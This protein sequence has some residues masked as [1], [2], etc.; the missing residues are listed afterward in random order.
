MYGQN[1]D[2]E[3]HSKEGT[4]IGYKRQFIVNCKLSYGAPA[5]NPVVTQVCECQVNLLER[6]FTDKEIRAYT[7]TY[8][9]NA[10][11]R[12]MDDDT[13]LQRQMRE[14]ASESNGLNVLSIPAYKRSFVDKCVQSLQ[15][16]EEKPVND[17]LALLYCN[18]AADILEKR[19]FSLDKMEDMND[20]S[21]FLYN[22]V[23][24]KCGSPYLEP[25]DLARDWKPGNSKDITGPADIDSVPVISVMGMHKVKITIG[26][27]TRIWLLDS[28][29]SDLLVSDEYLKMLKNQNVVSEIDFIGEGRYQLADSRIITCKRYKLN[30]LK[31]GRFTI[32][33]VIIAASK[34]T[35]EFLVG[36][37]VLNK[38]SQWMLDNKINLLILK[39]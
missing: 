5:D 18:C 11:S 35:N 9:A 4:V 24:H 38:F 39:K 8:K 17:T 28:G 37:T 25:S 20:P 15:T 33:N 22:E 32:K 3:L 29:A 12:L 31:I 30:E 10:L 19:K 21:S 6:R 14:C 13:V 7:R 34:E 23:A 26:G 1:Y 2:K 16:R 36:K 27:I